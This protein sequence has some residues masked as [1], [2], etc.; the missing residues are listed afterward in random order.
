MKTLI[1]EETYRGS[2]L[3]TKMADQDL[4]F[5]GVGAVGSNLVENM[6][7]Q[8]FSKISVIDMDRIEDH[9]RQ[10]QIWTQRE[11]G[12]LKTAMMKAR[13]FNVMG[14]TINDIPHKLEASNIKKFLKPGQIVIDSF[15]NV[16]SRRLVTEHCLSNKIEC[17]HIGLYQDVA[18]ICWNE[19]Y[20][21]PDKV[22]GLDVCEYPL[23]RNIIL[24]AVALGTESIIRYMDTGVKENLLITLKDFKISHI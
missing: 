10:T 11:A 20:R 7:R 19:R 5:C 24:L 12:Q 13:A 4:V 21:I 15:D 22:T 9:N 8:G 3:L 18:E 2:K 17:I 23:A 1:H 14:I 16:E 6:I